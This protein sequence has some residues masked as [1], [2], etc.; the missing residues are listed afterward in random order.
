MK[1]ACS[2][3]DGTLFSVT[4]GIPDETLD[5]IRAWRAVGHKFGI[6]TGRNHSLIQMEIDAYDIPFDFLICSN[7]ASLHTAD[8]TAFA[9]T[10]L[11]HNAMV[12]L[13]QSRHI[14]SYDGGMLFFTPARA[15][16]YRHRDDAPSSHLTTLARLEDAL[17]LNDM[18]QM[19]LAFQNQEEPCI[20][21]AEIEADFPNVFTGNIN[22]QYLDLNRKGVN[23]HQGIADLLRHK[24]WGDA[25]LF[26]IGD[27][28]NDL[29]MIK[30]YHGY[31]VESA[32]PFMHEAAHA[33]YAS[34]GAMLRMNM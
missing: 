3:Y 7:G 10:P 22:R 27:D 9:R 12:H 25:K 1:I 33:V 17:E 24:N 2:D 20:A 29:P 6:V 13:F 19:G 11:P 18:V 26:V 16:V 4:A 21:F 28:R 30:A 15:Y 34:V 32:Q 14:R 8:G 23:K 5:A 31:T